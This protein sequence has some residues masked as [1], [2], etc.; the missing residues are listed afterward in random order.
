MHGESAI[1][2]FRKRFGVGMG[3][4]VPIFHHGQPPS[5]VGDPVVF[6]GHL[7]AAF[8]GLAVES[9]GPCSFLNHLPGQFEA[10][11]KPLDGRV[12][13]EIGGR[14]TEGFA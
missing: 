6:V 3:G 4:A 13:G 7:G 8:R 5:F 10:K 14:S 1:H 12:S 9:F 2:I 11:L